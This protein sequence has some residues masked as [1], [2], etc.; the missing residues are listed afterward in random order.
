[1]SRSPKRS[2]IKL[3]KLAPVDRGTIQQRVYQQLREAL[4][5]G[6]FAPGDVVTLRSLADAFGT[7]AMPVREAV[8]QLV[9]ERPELELLPG[10]GGWSACLRVPEVEP[11]DKLVLRLLERHSLLLHPGWF[12]GFRGGVWLVLSLIVYGIVLAKPASIFGIA[13]LSFSGYVTLIPVLYMG[14]RS[15]K[16][17]A[18][19]AMVSVLL[20]NAALLGTYLEWLPGLGVEPVLWGLMGGIVGLV[21][22]TRLWPAE[23]EGEVEAALDE[24]ARAMRPG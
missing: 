15:Q 10:A 14:L 18:G 2:P 4:M 7:S 24:V 22:G 21:L 20:A 9:A 16:T 1:M 13:R 3:P 12:Y 8:R 23:V 19:G 11:E 17:S 5:K 6:R